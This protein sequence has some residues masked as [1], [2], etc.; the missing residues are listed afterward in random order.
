MHE[1]LTETNA[2]CA[3]KLQHIL[4]Y[5]CCTAYIGRQTP[6]LIVMAC[7]TGD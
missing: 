5:M 4:A 3:Q 2:Q 6:Q 7:L 1:L